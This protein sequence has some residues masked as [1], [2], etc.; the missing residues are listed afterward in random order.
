[1]LGRARQVKAGRGLAGH[2][3]EGRCWG[4]KKEKE[5]TVTGG[6]S[7]ATLHTGVASGKPTP[8][9]RTLASH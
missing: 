9:T 4:E 1:M 3:W 8:C 2:S 6:V 7:V 5:K